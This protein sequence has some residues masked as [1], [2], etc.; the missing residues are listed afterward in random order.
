M[1]L[2]VSSILLRIYNWLLLF[3]ERIQENK[4]AAKI[5]VKST[6]SKVTRVVNAFGQFDCI[7]L[8]T[9]IG[10]FVKFIGQ[11]YSSPIETNHLNQV[12]PV[13]VF[14]KATKEVPFF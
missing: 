5:I 13:N 3:G 1:I 14:V 12:V 8:L 9:L 6:G 10:R 4:T 2:C 7:K 11:R